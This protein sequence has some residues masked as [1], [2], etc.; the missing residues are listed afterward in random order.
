MA[1]V[2]E[3]VMRKELY[4]KSKTGELKKIDVSKYLNDTDFVVKIIER[5]IEERKIDI[6]NT[7]IIVSG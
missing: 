5:H 6:K 4:A 3:G 7:P 1:T 2:R